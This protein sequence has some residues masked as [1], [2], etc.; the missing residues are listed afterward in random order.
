MLPMEAFDDEVP[1]LRNMLYPRSCPGARP[2]HRA[3]E[4]RGKGRYT[5]HNGNISSRVGRRPHHFLIG[6]RNGPSLSVPGRIRRRYRVLHLR[7]PSRSLQG[8]YARFVGNMPPV[9]RRKRLTVDRSWKILSRSRR[10]MRFHSGLRGASQGERH[11]QH[12]RDDL[13][14][15]FPCRSMYY[16]SWTI[17]T[18]HSIR[19]YTMRWAG[20]ILLRICRDAVHP[21]D[22]LAK[23]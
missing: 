21:R 11:S 23:G 5:P 1:T 8:V 17:L 19:G 10:F 3:M 20:I 9:E 4:G 18:R 2:G 16:I 15:I 6:R 7:N 12:N 13:P 22:L 14:G